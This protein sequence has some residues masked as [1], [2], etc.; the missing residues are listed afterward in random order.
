MKKFAPLL[1]VFIFTI[2]F[3]EAT[4]AQSCSIILCKEVTEGSDG[5]DNILSVFTGFNSSAVGKDNVF[6]VYTRFQ[7][8]GVN[9]AH[10]Y[11]I[12]MKNVQ[13]E[14]IINSE[15]A[16]MNRSLTH[17]HV[18]ESRWTVNF[19]D[20]GIYT[21]EVWVDEKMV[22]YLNVRVGDL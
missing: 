3:S 14:I 19:P 2:G 21:I 7:D 20:V 15:D 16:F 13:G 11:D 9:V 17:T 6:T 5:N 1:F 22:E 18:A 8:F 12:R 10:T 4:K